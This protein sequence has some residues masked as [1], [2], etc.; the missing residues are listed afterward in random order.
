[1]ATADEKQVYI[2]RMVEIRGYSQDYHKILVENA[3]DTTLAMD[4][5]VSQ[6]YIKDRNLDKRTKELIII[7]AL[8]L[9]KAE[10]RQI[11]DHIEV[12]LAL[13]ISKEVILEAIELTIPGGGFVAFQRGVYAWAE[14]V[15]APRIEPTVEPWGRKGQQAG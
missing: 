14:A 5:L 2:N 9:V 4:A 7:A 1:M 11:I 8:V 3:Y 6:L 13:G 12:A 15:D 10:R